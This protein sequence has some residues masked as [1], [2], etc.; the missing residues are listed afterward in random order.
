ML[1]CRVRHSDGVP[2]EGRCRHQAPSPPTHTLMIHIPAPRVPRSVSLKA[3]KKGPNI[4]P[5][6]SVLPKTPP[7]FSH[8]PWT[9]TG[10]PLQPHL[11]GLPTPSQKP[12][13]LLDSGVPNRCFCQHMGHLQ[14]LHQ[15]LL[16]EV[17]RLAFGNRSAEVQLREMQGKPHFS[18][19]LKCQH[20]LMSNRG[21]L[22]C[23]GEHPAGSAP[24]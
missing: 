12:L 7:C 11:S 1:C 2:A 22:Q 6:Y 13:G 20:I 3:L 21:P 16:A 18:M 15:I 5:N 17:K 19:P 24:P 10:T 23:F 14:A 9:I 8:I 4:S